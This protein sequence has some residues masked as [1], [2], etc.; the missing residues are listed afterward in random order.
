MLG[1]VGNVP[2]EGNMSNSV[3]TYSLSYLG[4]VHAKHISLSSQAEII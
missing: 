4:N 1:Y 2:L 3:H